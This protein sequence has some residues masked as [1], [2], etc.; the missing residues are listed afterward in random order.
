MKLTFIFQAH[1]VLIIYLLCFTSEMFSRHGWRKLTKSL[2][3]WGAYFPVRRPWSSN[4]ETFLHLLCI[5]DKRDHRWLVLLLVSYCLLSV[6]FSSVQALNHVWLCS[7]PMGYRMPGFHCSNSC[8]SS[9]WCHPSISPSV[10]S[11]SSCLQSFPAS[12]AFYFLLWQ[13]AWIFCFSFFI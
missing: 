4:L 10:I 13:S 12:G 1:R 7:K 5:S 11:F 8:P 3:H 9:R 2:L 6:Q